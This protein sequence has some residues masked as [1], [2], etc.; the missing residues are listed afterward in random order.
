MNPK[1]I[2]VL[3]AAAISAK[4]PVLITGAPGIGKTDVVKQAAKQANADLIIMHPC[5]SDPTD[6]KGL[7]ALVGTQAE[8]LPFGDL[9]KLINATALTVCFL[10]DI[11]QAPPA[12]QAALMQ[13]LLAREING[14]KISEHVVFIAATNRKQDKAGVSGML[15]P[16]KSRF[17]SIVNMDVDH[18]S[19]IEWA[20][21]ANLP[22][23]I[24]SF[25]QFRPHL[26]HDFKASSDLVN[27]PCPRTVANLARLYNMNLP[28]EMH[29][30]AFS[31]AVGQGFAT[32][33]LAFLP[34]MKRLP[35]IDNILMG[36]DLNPP[37][38]ID[39]LFAVAVA[40]SRKVTGQNITNA[41]NYVEKM[42]KE[43]Q[44]LFVKAATKRDSELCNTREY[45]KWTT[46]N[47]D[48]LA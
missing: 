27:S 4:Q 42:Q 18:K 29:L 44:V 12:V 36:N 14:K 25:I 31:G 40:L 39:V 17:A 43:F 21:Q 19:W 37:K 28:K 35:N 30:E 9:L 33:F 48:Y 6:F 8:F 1:Q 47:S 5:V 46:T 11:G 24:I 15:E 10:D 7:P 16:V 20:I 26:L 45:I 34:I 38:E 2:S 13:L 22:L 3:I 41:F 23:E 32:E